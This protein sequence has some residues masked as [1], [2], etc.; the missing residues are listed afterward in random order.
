MESKEV[1]M[2]VFIMMCGLPGSGK[3]TFAKKFADENEDF[4]IFSSDEVRK[5]LY[6]SEEN[7]ENNEKVFQL[8]H[9]RIKA[10]LSSG[11]NVIYDACNISQKRRMAFLKEI[12]RFSPLK[13]CYFI[14]CPYEEVLENNRKR[15]RVVPEYAIK[16]MLKNFY[17]PQKFEGWDEIRIID[18]TRYP[19]KIVSLEDLFTGN[20][21][22]KG[23]CE[24]KHDNSHHK[25]TVGN[26]MIKAFKIATKETKDYNIVLAAF[27]H[28][29]G[30]PFC[31]TFMDSKGEI[32]KE[33]HYYQHHLVS[34]YMAV[35]YISELVYGGTDDDV[36]EV[37]ALITYHMMPYAW[38]NDESRRMKEKYRKLW[39]REFYEKIKVLHK[40]DELA[41]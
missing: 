30:K 38:K 1:K 8:L 15:D 2:P 10:E 37:L 40:I 41:H 33:A 32:T 36:M 34:A 13:I 18:N 3:S 19:E 5:E 25:L 29:I 9:K 35:P 31:K 27:L 6:G 17:I 16:R 21:K 20:K 11:G 26:H 14:Y 4:K 23:L 12:E 7:Q 28:D 39:G 24:V 22:I